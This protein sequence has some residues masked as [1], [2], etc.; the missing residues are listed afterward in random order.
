[1]SRKVLGITAHF[2]RQDGKPELDMEKINPDW[3]YVFD[4]P[5]STLCSSSLNTLLETGKGL[6]S[7]FTWRSTPQ[8]GLYWSNLDD[9]QDDD[10]C[11]I[12]SEEDKEYIRYL[13]REHT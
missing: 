2:R 11:V 8:E 10:G 6:S 7:A 9:E 13:I 1:M 4:N 5:R 12:L 3:S